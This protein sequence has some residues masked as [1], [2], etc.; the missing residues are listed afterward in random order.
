MTSIFTHIK[1]SSFLT[2]FTYFVFV[3]GGAILLGPCKGQLERPVSIPKEA[4]FEKKFNLYKLAANGEYKEWHE[5]GSLVAKGK[6]D[7]NGQL[8]GYSERYNYRT[9]TVISK[10]EILNG[11]RDGLWLYYFSDGKL[12][13]EQNYK[14]GYRKKQ[15]WVTS[16][17]IGNE[18]G[19]YIRYFKNGRVNEKGFYDGGNRT[20]DW[21]RYYPDTKVES[22][23]S[24]S[25]DKKI[26]EWFYFFPNGVR[27]ASELY[28]DSGDFIRRTTYYPNGKIRCTASISL[29]PSCE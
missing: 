19:S 13:I 20:G 15:F 5:S 11:E 12:Y 14:A 23:G 21:V 7:S 18:N 8:N 29:T 1:E 16:P 3:L 26:G 22:K 24:Y 6:L 2:V 17:E 27:E 9:G 4:N 28:S 25:S 10:G